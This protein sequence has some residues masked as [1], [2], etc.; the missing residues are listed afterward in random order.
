MS[1]PA[2]WEG[3]LLVAPGFRA[4]DGYPLSG[5]KPEVS[6]ATDECSTDVGASAAA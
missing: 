1:S 4:V 5:V 3:G 6:S 2:S